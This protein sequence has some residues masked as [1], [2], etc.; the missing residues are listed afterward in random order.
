MWSAECKVKTQESGV[1]ST[2][3]EVKSEMW[4][5]N[6]DPE[7]E[8]SFCYGF[9]TDDFINYLVTLFTSEKLPTADFG[10]F[11]LDKDIKVIRGA[12][13]GIKRNKNNGHG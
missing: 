11:A 4:V 7:T 13:L 2:E 8:T 3:C 12:M 5:Q 9:D 1:G 10:R 6:F